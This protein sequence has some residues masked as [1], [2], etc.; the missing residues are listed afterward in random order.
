MAMTEKDK[1]RNLSKTG[2]IQIKITFQKCIKL[3]KRG[4]LSR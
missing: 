1:E 2:I 4:G 3:Q